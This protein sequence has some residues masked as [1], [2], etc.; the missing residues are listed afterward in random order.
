MGFTVRRFPHITYESRLRSLSFVM[1]QA[2][3]GL[4]A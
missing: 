1:P 3:C 4:P 2:A